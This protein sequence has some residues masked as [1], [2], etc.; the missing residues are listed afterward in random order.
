MIGG[1]ASQRQRNVLYGTAPEF[2]VKPLQIFEW[3][4]TT[5]TVLDTADAESVASF[6]ETQ[7]HLIEEI[8]GLATYYYCESSF[9]G[10]HSSEI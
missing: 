5:G 6:Y 4:C 2:P 7:A 1:I 10:A 8:S 9:G 3:F